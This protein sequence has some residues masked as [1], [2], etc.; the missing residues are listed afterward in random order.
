M[1]EKGKHGTVPQNVCSDAPWANNSDVVHDSI[2]EEE[3]PPNITSLK[4]VP[5]FS[6]GLEQMLT[7]WYLEH[8]LFYDSSHKDYGNKQKKE[9]MLSEKAKELNLTG[10]NLTGK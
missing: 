7:I 2:S 5:Q 6:A 9:H 1:D 3:E 8:P 10:I 4:N